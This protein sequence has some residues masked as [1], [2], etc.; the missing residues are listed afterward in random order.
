MAWDKH[1][2]YTIHVDLDKRSIERAIGEIKAYE[3]ELYEKIDEFTRRLAEYGLEFAQHRIIDYGAVDTGELYRSMN[4]KRGD[5]IPN[6]SQWIIFTDCPYA[7]FV[8]FGT[9]PVGAAN[10]H[11]SGYNVY[12]STGWNYW[13][14]R[15][16][17]W[18]HTNGMRSRPFM[19]DTRQYIT[20]DKIIREVAKEV[21]G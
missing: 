6:G 19:W 17:R 4:M 18:Q 14:E 21:F 12:R 13:N 16:S 15:A 11:P 9:G 2:R 3:A 7:Q 1:N 10:P 8:E 20:Q 5:V